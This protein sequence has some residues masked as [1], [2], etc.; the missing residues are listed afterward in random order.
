[1]KRKYLHIEFY[2]S[3]LYVYADDVEWLGK[4]LTLAQMDRE[5]E[6]KDLTN[7]RGKQRNLHYRISLKDFENEK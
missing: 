3:K 5:C 1:M 4:P 7:L 6:I 2:H